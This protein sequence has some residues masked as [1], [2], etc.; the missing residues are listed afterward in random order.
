MFVKNNQSMVILVGVLVF[1]LVIMPLLEEKNRS[2]KERFTNKVD[3]AKYTIGDKFKLD[4]KECSKDCCKH[5]Q[6]K[7]P[8]MPESKRENVLGTNLMCNHGVGG[9]C[10]CAEKDDIKFLTNRGDNLRKR[11]CE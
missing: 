11:K 3:T 2:E 1:F 10:V 5:V 4:T 8:H 6:W 9:G 7:V